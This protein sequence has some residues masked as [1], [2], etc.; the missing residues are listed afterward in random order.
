MPSTAAAPDPAPDAALTAALAGCLPAGR[1]AGPLHAYR[2]VDST[3]TVCRRLGDG[4]APEGTV[5]VADG[6][7]A[8]R[9]QRGRTWTAPPGT[10]LLV[11]CLLRPPLPPARWPELTLLAASA[12]VDA[13][14]ALTPL[15]PSVRAPNDVYAGDRKL[16]GVLAESVVGASPLVVLGIGIN[17]SQRPDDWPPELRGR[18]V[19]LAELGA[20]VPRPALLAEL[21]RRLAARYEAYLAARE[22][23]LPPPSPGGW[24]GGPK[25]EGRSDVGV[26]GGVG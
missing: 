22:P 4:G 11:S 21:L 17:V 10:G 3:Q 24:R 26:A 19:S 23:V 14:A 20:T 25:A 9:G 6:Q 2:A 15:R 1:L 16:A 7:W 5:V 12:V 13:V 18:A 8:G